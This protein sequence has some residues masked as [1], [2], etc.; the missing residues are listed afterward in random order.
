MNK[1]CL[2]VL[3]ANYWKFAYMLS[4]KEIQGKRFKEG[5]SLMDLQLFVP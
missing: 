3:N 1:D 5:S 4:S 2:S